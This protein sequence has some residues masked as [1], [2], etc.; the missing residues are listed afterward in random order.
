MQ[1]KPGPVS[2]FAS[3]M[4]DE[5]F[6]PTP[7]FIARKRLDFFFN[8]IQIIVGTTIACSNSDNQEWVATLTLIELKS[9]IPGKSP[10]LG[11]LQVEIFKKE[12]IDIISWGIEGMHPNP[13]C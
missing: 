3:L 6:S 1:V 7:T 11:G 2:W 5:S 8:G 9:W 10:Y 4:L 12:H 13:A